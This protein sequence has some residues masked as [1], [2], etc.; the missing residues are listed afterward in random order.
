MAKRNL[1]EEIKGSL[2]E[3]R[4]N[5]EGLVRYEIKP[6]DVKKVRANLG[7]TQAQ[8]ALCLVIPIKTLQKWEQGT[9]KPDGAANTLLR[10]MEREPDAVM[11]ALHA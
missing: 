11:R 4:D 6:V 9:R 1:F 8:F 7:M 2:E 10:V 5:P 3:L